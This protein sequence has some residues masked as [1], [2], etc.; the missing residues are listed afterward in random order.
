LKKLLFIGLIVLNVVFVKSQTLEGII[1]DQETG[2]VLPYASVYVS[3]TNRGTVTNLDGKFILKLKPG[4]HTL[5]LRYIGYKSDSISVQIPFSG[6]LGLE[7]KKQSIVL[8]EVV[9]TAGEDP[10]YRII[11]Q[12]I[13][14]KKE[15]KKGLN[16]FKYD[17]YSKKVMTSAG[18]VAMVEE[19]FAIGYNKTGEWEKEFI[20]KTHVTE[21]RKTSGG[22]V[23]IMIGNTYYLDFSSDTLNIMQNKVFLPLAD[24]AFDYYDYKLLKTVEYDDYSVYTIRVIPLSDIQPLVKGEINIEGKTFSLTSIELENNEGIRF[25]YV[26]DF[27]VNFRQSLGLIGK[28]WL[29]NYVEFYSSLEFNFSGLIGLE[30]ISIHTVN[31][32]TNYILNE[33]IPDS[34][35]NAVRSRH[36]GYASD[37]TIAKTKPIELTKTDIDSLRPLPLTNDEIRAFST[38]DSTMTMDKMIKPTGALASL[39]P[40]EDDTDTTDSVF[41]TAME[42]LSEYIYLNNNR[43]EGVSAGIRFNKKVGSLD[44]KNYLA[45]S[46]NLKKIIFESKVSYKIKTGLINEVFVGGYNK[47]SNWQGYTPYPEIMNAIGVTFG[48]ED[49]FNYYKASGFYAGIKSALAD[50]FTMGLSYEYRNHKNILKT[51]L[52][53]FF[54]KN[55][56]LRINPTINEGLDSRITISAEM[57]KSPFDIKVRPESGFIFAADISS[58][59]IGS[60]FDY[61]KLYFNGHLYIPTFFDELFLYPYLMISLNGS[62]V[63]GDFGTQHLTTPDVSL[64]FYNHPGSLRGINPYQYAGNK[65]VTF[66]IEHNWRTILFQGLGL[67]FLTDTHLDIITGVSAMKIWNNSGHNEYMWKNKEYWEAYIGVARIFALLRLDYCYNSEREHHFRVSTSVL[68]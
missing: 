45:Y 23:Q 6:R 9:I 49:Q 43:A 20:Q 56:T 55:R 64:G 41:G 60:D 4:N 57:G 15:N 65:L 18:E 2:E 37:T 30:P 28:Y 17:A 47:V 25:P 29:P 24:N 34:V 67:D 5:K 68:F 33:E 58:K 39:I 52:Y 11:R 35:I 31:N 54:N 63:D 10:A 26:N 38:L 1:T 19:A 27:V 21:N 61:R 36:R 59:S 44:T 8:A 46:K 48:Y 16:N 22:N 51:D 14:R 50:D 32:I 3:G 62:I 53:R 13:A 40:D 42:Y 7:L 12:A 66:Q